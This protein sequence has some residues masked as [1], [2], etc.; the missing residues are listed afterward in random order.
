MPKSTRPE[1]ITLSKTN[2]ND[3]LAY[4]E[5]ANPNYISVPIWGVRWQA[6]HGETRSASKHTF[7]IGVRF[8]QD[9]YHSCILVMT[10]Q[11]SMPIEGTV[12]DW[13]TSRPDLGEVL[14]H[15]QKMFKVQPLN[16]LKKPQTR[17]DN[18]DEDEDGGSSGRPWTKQVCRDD[19]GGYYYIGQDEEYHRCDANGKEIQSTEKKTGYKTSNPYQIVL[20]FSNTQKQTYYHR[21]GQPELC[22]LQKHSSGTYYFIDY[23]GRECNAQYVGSQPRWMS[24]K[25]VSQHTRGEG[26]YAQ[27]SKPT[28]L[29]DPKTGRLYCIDKYGKACWV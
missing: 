17:R 28:Y 24:R 14:Q 16:P 10:G 6:S 20:V 12:I 21:H 27:T 26:G 4:L 18:D 5:H 15:Y 3:L 29:T 1:T 25:I 19:Y 9:H 22:S 7:H 23:K 2:K 11:G 13:G 8:V